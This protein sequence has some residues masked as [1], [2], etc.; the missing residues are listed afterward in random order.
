MA[1]YSRDFLTARHPHYKEK[2]EDWNFH[3]LYY[4]VG[5]DYLDFVKKAKSV[6]DLANQ[7]TAGKL[8]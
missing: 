5:Q 6:L 1:Q 2:F 4:L 8:S 7:K 3:M